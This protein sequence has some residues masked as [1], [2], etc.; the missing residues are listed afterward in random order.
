[1]AADM[2]LAMQGIYRRDGAPAPQA[3]EGVESPNW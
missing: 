1:D 2:A 3:E